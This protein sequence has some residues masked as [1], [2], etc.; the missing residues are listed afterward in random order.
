MRFRILSAV[1]AAIVWLAP[2]PAVA[3]TFDLGSAGSLGI[4]GTLRQEI[5]VATDDDGN[6]QNVHEFQDEGRD[7]SLFALRN[8]LDFSWRYS[9]GLTGFARLR[10]WSELAYH[11]DD[12][13]DSDVDPFAGDEFPGNGSL[14]SFPTRSDTVLVDLK[15]A[16]IDVNQGSW[17]LRVGKQQIA[18]GESIFFRS[19]D[20]V[21]SLDLR[22]H[23]IFDVI[24][25]EY[26]DERIGQ[27]G[28]RGSYRFDNLPV[29]L[30]IEGFVTDFTPTFLAPTGS[31]YASLPAQVRLD[32][33]GDIADAR[34]KAVFGGRLLARWKGLDV[35]ANF[36][37]RPQHVGVF[38]FERGDNAGTPFAG[39]PFDIDFDLGFRGSAE[40]TETLVRN[41]FVPGDVV[42]TLIT[43]WGVPASLFTTPG[44]LDATL[45]AAN[46][47]GV[48]T[49][50]FPRVWIV[51]GGAN[52]M[53]QFAPGHPLRFMDS[54]LARVEGA[55]SLD[56]EF[57]TPGLSGDFDEEDELNMAV[58]LEKW[59]KF[60]R[61]LP[62]TYIVLEWWY[63]S[64]SDFLERQVD[65]WGDE[66]FQIIGLAIQ[67]Q[68][69][70]NR[71]R[72][73]ASV[74]YDPSGGLWVQPGLRWKPRDDVQVDLYYNLFHGDETEDL[75]GT[76][77]DSDE[78]F[79]RLS[80]FF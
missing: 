34:D 16:Y 21:N 30:E 60:H 66:S 57:T 32:D 74:V 27:L 56:K 31:A 55:V 43:E 33:A 46:L 76:F 20:M 23:S 65:S 42:T 12:A 71:L 37:S 59:H 29:P 62:A 22:R 15:Q 72:A 52:Y 70:Q 50:E 48:V 25:E 64:E 14:L 39:T 68:L 47:R 80:Y 26:A 3:E 2:Q 38:R 13:Y 69:M 54:V 4:K 67:Q 7:L 49:R 17:W 73:D 40:L 77:Q 36:V 11:I 78:A 28:I 53:F 19:L 75:F 24:S 79:V 44:A 58:T 41:R 35:Q 8:E 5:A 63:K 18:W 45:D 10:T 51:G 9:D 61:N 6:P 1:P